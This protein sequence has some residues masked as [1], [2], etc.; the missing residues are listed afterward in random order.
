ME[1]LLAFL[2]SWSAEPGVVERE[3]PRAAAAVAAAYAS[4]LPELPP[5][6]PPPG[7]PAAPEKCPDQ[8]CPPKGRTQP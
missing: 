5:L 3:A 4:L 2:T 1:W 7:P 8:K 6:P